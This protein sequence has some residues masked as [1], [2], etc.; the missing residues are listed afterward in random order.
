MKK[1]KIKKIVVLTLAVLAL[2]STMALIA[3]AANQTSQEQVEY[4]TIRDGWHGTIVI[5][6]QTAMGGVFCDYE[7][8]WITAPKTITETVGYGDCLMVVSSSYIIDGNGNKYEDTITATND[9]DELVVKA[10]LFDTPSETWHY[11]YVAGSFED[12]KGMYYG[13]N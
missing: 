7:N 9:T 8:T 11:G 2:V 10:G 3:S 4:Y 1:L 13:S 12:A 6:Y 5:N